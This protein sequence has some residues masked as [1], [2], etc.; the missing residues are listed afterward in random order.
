MKAIACFALLLLYICCQAQ[1]EK[2]FTVKKQTG[3]HLTPDIDTLVAGV[4]TTFEVT[5]ID[6]ETV[7]PLFTGGK[8]KVKGNKITLTADTIYYNSQR[9]VFHL[10]TIVDGRFKALYKKDFIIISTKV[11]LFDFVTLAPPSP[12][13]GFYWNSKYLKN[14]DTL[15]KSIISS[16]APIRLNTDVG[17]IDSFK[18]A[19]TVN[20]TVKT[21]SCNGVLVN[22]EMLAA[23]R[24]VKAGERFTITTI[25]YAS[26]ARP[27][28]AG[29]FEIYVTALTPK[30]E[31]ADGSTFW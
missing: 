25:N 8:I 6:L 23:L 14:G 31:N 11:P 22:G 18:M 15:S 26:S 13:T 28:T 29:P 21:Y 10:R 20:G 7:S 1:E 24:N 9:C 12:V 5:G 17:I 27:Q 30:M 19:F 2:V 3:I 16:K 4:P